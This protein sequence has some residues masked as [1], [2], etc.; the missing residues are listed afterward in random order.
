MLTHFTGRNDDYSDEEFEADEDEKAPEVS[1][2][3][4]TELMV[5][6]HSNRSSTDNI[7]ER[8]NIPASFLHPVRK[9]STD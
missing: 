8:S 5:D 1:Q 2:Y 6:P 3:R 7:F 9:Y 4:G